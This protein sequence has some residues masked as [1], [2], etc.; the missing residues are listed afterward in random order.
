MD[1]ESY[2]SYCKASDMKNTYGRYLTRKIAQNKF[3]ALLCFPVFI[4]GKIIPKNKKLKIFG[5]MNGYDIVDNAK[6]MFINEFREGY[7]F[8]TKNKDKLSTPIFKNVYPIYCFSIRGL[9]LQ[10]FAAEV[11]YTHS[12]FDFFSPLIMGAKIIALWHG[13]P[14]KKINTALPEQQKYLKKI[15]FVIYTYIMPYKYYA[16]CNEVY[17]PAN[18]LIKI[19]KQSFKIGNP[20]IIIHKQPRNIYAKKYEKMRQKRILYAPTYRENGNIYA[21]MDSL[22]FFQDN[23]I[24]YIIDNKI[25]FVIRPHPIDMQQLE[26]KDL[27]SCYKLDRSGDIYDSIGSY[28]LLITDYSSLY[29]DAL[30]L[31]IEVKILQNDLKKYCQKNGLFEEFYDYILNNSYSKLDCILENF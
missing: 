15:P 18:N 2:I 12:I 3:I 17:C 1:K 16:Y 29:Y 22:G 14:G 20:K 13:V 28:N 26:A 8:I 30:E 21:M 6:Y 11:Y 19:Y 25:D 4:F 5:S 31:G 27:P 9:I 24:Q 10:L 23:I 7:Y